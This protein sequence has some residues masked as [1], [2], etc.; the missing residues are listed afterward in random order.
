MVGQKQLTSVVGVALLVAALGLAIAAY[1]AGPLPGDL[2]VTRGLQTAMP[3]EGTWGKLLSMVENAVWLAALLLITLML[4]LRRWSSALLLI[5]GTVCAIVFGVLLLKGLVA[6][7]RPTASL[8]RLYEQ[9]E[10]YSFPSSTT[11]L[12]TVLGGLLL[13]EARNTGR[14]KLWLAFIVALV[15][16]TGLARILVGAHWLT[17]IVGAWLWGGVLLVLIRMLPR[18][19]F[20]RGR[21]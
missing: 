8:V 7:P 5:I 9:Y 13:F 2:A 14:R 1:G 19:W 10:G 6:R 21:S 11:L 16:L 15:L 12:A 20:R 17:D 4:L 3:V 18:R